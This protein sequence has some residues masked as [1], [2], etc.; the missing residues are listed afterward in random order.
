VSLVVLDADV[1]SALL[2]RRAPD[3]MPAIARDQVPA[4]TFV[5]VGELTM[6]TLVRKWGPR[7]LETMR[8]FLADLVVL[9]PTDASPPAGARSRPT[10]SSAFV[11]SRQRLLIA[12]YCLVGELPLATF[13]IKDFLDFEQHDGLKRLR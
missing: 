5:I 2:R 13:N 7:I 9:P 8:T 4:I 12:A 11:P 6:W 1:A 10:P 3:S